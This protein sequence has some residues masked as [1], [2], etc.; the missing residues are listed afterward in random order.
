MGWPSMTA[1]ASMPPTPQPTTPRPLIMVVWLS[2][3]TQESGYATVSPP[4]CLVQHALA[5]YSRF[6][7]WT[8]PVAGG[9]HAEVAQ[10]LLAPLE[11]LVALV[12]ALELL[13]GVDRERLGRAEGVDLHAVV[14]D[15]VALDQRVDELGSPP[16]FFIASRMAARSTTQGT[17]VK[18][19]STTR[20]GMKGISSL[21]GLLAFQLARPDTSSAV[22]TKPSR[23]RSMDSSSTLME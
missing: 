22:T 8:M 23:L 18:S 12:V 6:T 14:D 15:Q 3:P 11:E 5:R 1:S 2:V 4:A 13:G 7:W 20:P 10:A 21:A 16:S 9:T 17:P 19:C